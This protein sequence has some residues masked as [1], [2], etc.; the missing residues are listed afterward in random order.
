MTALH[1]FNDIIVDG[2]NY[3][4]GFTIFQNNRHYHY[5][6]TSIEDSDG[7]YINCLNRDNLGAMFEKYIETE[8]YDFCYK[9]S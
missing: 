4:V 1:L 5:K 3:T 9:Y 7:N 2:I 8:I 6:L